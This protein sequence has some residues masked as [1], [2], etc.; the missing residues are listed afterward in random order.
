MIGNLFNAVSIA[1]M[2]GVM[3]IGATNVRSV[4]TYPYMDNIPNA[5]VQQSLVNKDASVNVFPLDNQYN[6]IDENFGTSYYVSY[7]GV[8]HEIP[9]M[10]TTQLNNDY[11]ASDIRQYVYSI[12]QENDND[13]L[14]EYPCLFGCVWYP[15]SM[16]FGGSTRYQ[17][18]AY[19][20]GNPLYVS[21]E[22]TFATL[23]QRFNVEVNR[24]QMLPLIPVDADFDKFTYFTLGG[25]EFTPL[26]QSEIFDHLGGLS[27]SGG[28]ISGNAHQFYDLQESYNSL[29]TQFQLVVGIA[30][31]YN[32]SVSDA[33]TSLSSVQCTIQLV[34]DVGDTT[35]YVNGYSVGYDKG[36]T[37]GYRNG[38]ADGIALSNHGQFGQ[39]FNAIADT[40]LRFIYGLFNFDLFGISC[41]VIILTFLTGIIVFGV[42][43]KF[44]H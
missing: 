26:N 19:F 1:L 36:Y 39:L 37:D 23:T 29:Y 16:V 17:Y 24:F 8:L 34:A 14:D 7:D 10:S 38:Y 15:V 6:T 2:S 5:V 32:A 4:A 30:N 13:Y 25:Y 33:L 11:S 40:P 28:S 31:G 12:C 44:W 27:I 9:N 20:F 3:V 42:V 22:F 41:L 18:R 21:C 43:K 35:S